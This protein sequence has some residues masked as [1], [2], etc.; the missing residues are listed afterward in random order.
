[1]RPDGPRKWKV[2]QMNETKELDKKALATLRHEREAL[3]ERARK[4]IKDQ[5]RDIKA[6]RAALQDGGRTVPEIAA[7]IPM[8]STRVLLYIAALK[9]Y[10][11][12]A[13]GP[14]DGDYFKYVL[15]GA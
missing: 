4:T 6:I 12:V 3:I 14:K 5:T 15:A 1:M 10:G 2:T 11:H 13:E 9:K 7:A 8:P